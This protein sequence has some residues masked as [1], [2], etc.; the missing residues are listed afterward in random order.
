MANQVYLAGGQ[1]GPGLESAMTNFW[2]L[3]LARKD[4]PDAFR[5]VE[6]PPWPGPGRAYNITTTQ[7]DGYHDGVY[8]ISGR[9]Q[10][11]AGV[12]FLRDTW[13]YLPALGTWRQRAGAPRELMAGAGIGWGQSHIFILSGA[14]GALFDQADAL[15]DAHPGF[16]KEAFAYHTITDTWTSAGTSPANQVA[17]VPVRWTVEG[18]DCVVVASGE[19]R[20]RVRTPQVWAVRPATVTPAFAPRT[21]RSCS[22]TSLPWLAWARISPG[23]TRP[24]TTIS[25]A[26]KMAWWAA[27]CSIFATM[28]SSVTYTGIPSKAYAQDWTYMVGNFMIVAVA[29]IAIYVALPFFGRLTSPAR[30]NTLRNGS[31]AAS[32]C[33]EARASTCSTFSEWAWSCR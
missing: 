3:D 7:H 11:E 20:P 12:E 31:T 22:S 23:A 6:L 24:P 30:T 1:S 29:P 17:T 32:A 13:E 16:P 10:G 2:M 18:R 26:A 19:T 14:D 4:A 27:G 33:S 25:A 28:L 15:Q 8:V 5:W 9:R 21:T